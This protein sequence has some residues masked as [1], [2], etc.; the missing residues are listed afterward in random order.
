MSTTENNTRRN[1]AG[2]QFRPMPTETKASIKTTELLFYLAAV[3]AVGVASVLVGDRGPQTA[4]PFSTAQALQYITFLTIG[5][6][7]SR[8]LAKA[9]SCN[10]SDD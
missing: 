6:M 2:E 5:Y 1:L 10:H 8:G 7:I 9:G 4:D 3:L